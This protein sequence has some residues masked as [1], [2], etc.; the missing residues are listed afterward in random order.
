MVWELTTPRV[1]VM[2]FLDGVPVIDFL[3]G[4]ETAGGDEPPD[5]HLAGL[6]GFDGFDRDA[7]ARAI[8]DNFLG[9]AFRH[10][11]FHA[12]LHPA[13]LLIRPGNVVGYIDFGITGLL[14][15]HARR[16]LVAMTVAYTRGDLAAMSAAFF[17][18]STLARGANP[19]AFRRGLEELGRD[20]YERSGRAIRLRKSFTLMM[21]DMLRLSRATGV[22]PE[23][24]VIKY[25]RSAVIID[26]LV[27]RI[28]P[29]LD[30]GQHLERV[31]T[32]RLREE[33]LREALS[34]ARLVD[35]VATVAELARDGPARL[36]ALAD[37]AQ[38]G[39]P[40]VRAEDAPRERPAR[41]TPALTERALAQT[42]F[43]AGAGLLAAVAGGPPTPGWNVFTI[44]ALLLAAGLAALFDTLRRLA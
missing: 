27:R 38:D 17:E 16:H 15:R 21:L 32:R 44:A 40:A 8:I 39:E 10:G 1:L 4:L 24:D 41:N 29:G 36:S 34:P 3:R 5:S 12:D 20:W 11:L 33:R 35:W 42:A 14:S 18:V 37:R 31:C 30:A 7:Y 2:D 28:A 25:I 43:V 9:D 19:A 6:A 23:R 26:G 13:N 22:W